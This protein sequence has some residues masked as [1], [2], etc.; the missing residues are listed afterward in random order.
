LSEL[1]GGKGRARGE[2]NDKRVVES[3]ASEQEVNVSKPPPL[4]ASLG[5]VDIGEIRR[6]IW[7]IEGV[8]LEIDELKARIYSCWQRPAIA[9]D[10]T[11]P[12]IDLRLFFH[13]DGTVARIPEIV[14][15]QPSKSPMAA[16]VAESAIRAVIDCGPFGDILNRD[17][18]PFWD[19]INVV[20]DP[21]EIEFE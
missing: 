17:T 1:S 4:N 14:G 8:Q 2:G 3:R 6:R 20:F 18:Y 16:A 5:E 9:L 13:A 21:N 7:A 19:E 10:Q 12:S 15:V 11:A